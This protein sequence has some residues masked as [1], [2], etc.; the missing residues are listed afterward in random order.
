MASNFPADFYKDGRL[1]ER[2]ST[3]NMT[4]SSVSKSDE[5]LYRCHIS[6]AGES[7]ESRLAVT[8]PAETRAADRCQ[9]VYAVITNH[10]KAEDQGEPSTTP[11]Y[12]A[13][14]MGPAASS[15]TVTPAPSASTSPLLED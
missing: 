9:P 2:S 6:G 11:V 10:G 4:I 8:V 1:I 15:S 13:L 12:Y 5:G 14:S 3:G 7:P